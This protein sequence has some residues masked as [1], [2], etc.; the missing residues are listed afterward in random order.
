M[1]RYCLAPFN[2]TGG[3]A[4]K[5][6]MDMLRPSADDVVYDIGCGDARLLV[7]IAELHGCTCVGIEHDAELVRRAQSLIHEKGVETKITIRHEDATK[8]DFS[9]A[10]LIFLYLVPKGIQFM[11]PR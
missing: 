11:L 3:G 8:A 7:A 1:S 4:I 2:P 9:D 6:A 10:T 5:V